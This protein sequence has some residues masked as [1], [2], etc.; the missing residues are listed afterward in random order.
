MIKA[1]ESIPKKGKSAS[2]FSLIRADIESAIRDNINRFE[3][4]GDYNYKYLTQYARQAADDVMREILTN[5]ARK[6]KKEWGIIEHGDIRD[7]LNYGRFRFFTRRYLDV[8]GF[9]ADDRRHVYGEIRP[10]QLEGVYA[11]MMSQAKENAERR[12]QI[13]ADAEKRRAARGAAK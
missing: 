2:A 9:N 8:M 10:K 12:I 1:V 11:E 7:V 13:R 5:M 3:F 6:R 4:V